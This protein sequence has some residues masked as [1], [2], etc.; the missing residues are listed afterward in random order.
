MICNITHCIPCR[1]TAAISYMMFFLLLLTLASCA[2]TIKNTAWFVEDAELDAIFESGQ[3]L[4]DYQYYYSGPDAEPL[5]ILGI[6]RDYHFEKGLW[7]EIALT[8]SQFQKWLERIQNPY[9][10]LRYRYDGSYI[11]DREGDRV[12][13]WFSVIDRVTARIDSEKKKITVHIPDNTVIP[14]IPFTGVDGG[15][16]S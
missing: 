8:E 15:G 12:G 1:R 4:P 10:S 7:K 11:V 3:I 2:P 13:I 16:G 5:A 14:H 9:R 6:R